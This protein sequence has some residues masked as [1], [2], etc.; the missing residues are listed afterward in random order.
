[1]RY[2]LSPFF[3]FCF[4]VPSLFAGPLPDVPHIVVTGEYEIRAI[5][6]I[7]TLALSIGETG[8]EVAKARDSIENR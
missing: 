3:L 6:D 1:M 7:V 2:Y 5:P 4:L 8:F